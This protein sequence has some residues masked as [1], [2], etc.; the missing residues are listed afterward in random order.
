MRDILLALE[1]RIG[2]PI[3][4]QEPIVTFIPEYAAYLLNRLDVGK[5]GKRRT[6]EA[7]ESELKF[8]G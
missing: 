2:G 8:W 3:D 5:D 7:K 1:G 6:R 4:A